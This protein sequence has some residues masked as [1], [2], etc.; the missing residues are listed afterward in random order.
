MKAIAKN[1]PDIDMPAAIISAVSAAASTIPSES[2]MFS[3]A[4][5]RAILQSLQALPA[6]VAEP[7]KK[8][9]PCV[10]TKPEEMPN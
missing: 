9:A 2:M 1:I 6:A 4:I 8:D 5:T 3:E 10:P 7:A